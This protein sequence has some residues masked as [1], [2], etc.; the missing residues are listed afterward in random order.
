MHRLSGFQGALK[1]WH[2]DEWSVGAIQQELCSGGLDAGFFQ[3]IFQADP[4]PA[5][6]PD[7]AESPLGAGYVRLEKAA[8]VSGAFEH[9]DQFDAGEFLQIVEGEGERVIDQSRDF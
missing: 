5:G 8:A 6:I 2:F 3:D 7:A 1:L 4:A 9:A